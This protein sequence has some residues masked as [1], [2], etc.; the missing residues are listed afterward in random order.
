[1]VTLRYASLAQIA[2]ELRRRVY[3][4]KA[5]LAGTIPK[6]AGRPQRL[7]AIAE[8]LQRLADEGEAKDSDQSGD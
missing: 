1:M 7:E 5:K 2:T 4:E 8:K 6:P 3:G